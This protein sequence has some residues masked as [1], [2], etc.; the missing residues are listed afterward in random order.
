MMG[1]IP[2][3][4]AGYVIMDMILNTVQLAVLIFIYM[5]IRD[6]NDR[7]THAID[8][9]LGLSEKNKVPY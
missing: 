8:V 3:N 7:T 2:D 1:I 9:M 6:S 5:S 4:M